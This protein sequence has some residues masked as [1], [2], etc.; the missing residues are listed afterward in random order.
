[1]NI[2]RKLPYIASIAFIVLFTYA[3]ASKLIEQE[4]FEIQISQSPLLSAYATTLA[5]SVPAS[6]IVIS[7]GLSIQI[8]RALALYLSY[9][10]MVVFTGY[11]V[12]IL[13]FGSQIP[14]SCGGILSSMGWTQHLVFNVFFV[15]LAACAILVDTNNPF[16]QWTKI[17][18]GR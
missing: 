18:T 6:E 8:F 14:C 2:R 17:F 3:A 4:T 12:A 10:L 5:W 1:M 15:L 11:I 13:N 16:N 7:L 9:G